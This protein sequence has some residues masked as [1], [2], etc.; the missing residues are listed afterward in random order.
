MSRI[1]ICGACGNHAVSKEKFTDSSCRTWAVEVVPTSIVWKDGRIIK[2]K[3]VGDEI[4]PGVSGMV[5]L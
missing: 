1:W 2:A 4:K 5:S 3:A